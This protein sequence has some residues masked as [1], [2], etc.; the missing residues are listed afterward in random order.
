MTPPTK[1]SPTTPSPTST[2][3]PNPACRDVETLRDGTPVRVEHARD[4]RG[5]ALLL[6]QAIRHDTT[7]G[8]IPGDMAILCHTHYHL[9]TI[10][11]FLTDW[12]IPLCPL[13]DW[14]GNPDPRVKIGTIHRS[15]GLDFSAVYIPD[16]TNPDSPR[17]TQ[18]EDSLAH[19]INREFVA[20]V[21]AHVTDSGSRP[22][23]LAE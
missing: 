6:R 20:H 10:T 5:I 1:S 12:D 14:D 2:P 9:N 19:H 17:S 8:I 3:H 23:P 11:S 15:K 4:Y 22:S 16:L 7:D 21:P 13:A 18:A